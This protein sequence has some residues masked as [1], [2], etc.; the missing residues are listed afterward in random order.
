MSEFAR[1]F[2]DSVER[3]DFK[4]G[5][6]ITGVVASIEG[7]NVY[8]HCGLK[9]DARIP[10]HEFADV[11]TDISV[12]VGEEVEVALWSTDNGHGETIVSRELARRIQ[13]WKDLGEAYEKG[14]SV[15]GAI[16][17]RIKGGFVVEIQALRAFLPGSLI[18]VRPLYDSTEL[19]NQPLQFKVIKFDE[20]R[21]NV[22]VSR[23]AVLLE[24]MRDDREGLLAQIQEGD[25]RE[26]T[27]KNLTSYGAF[28][29]LGGIDG[30]LHNS[31]ISWKRVQHPSDVLKQGDKIKVKVLSFE[32][33]RIRISLGMKQL[34]PD[35]WDDLGEKYPPGTRHQGRVTSVREYG[36]FV[37]LSE[38]VEGLV[39]SSQMDWLNPKPTP[40][41][42][43]SVDDEVEVQ[44]LEVDYERKRISL[45]LKQCRDN[46]WEKFES[47]AQIGD[48][49]KGSIRDITDFGIFVAIGE[50]MDG[51]VHLSDISWSK[52]GEEA[53]KEF[54]KGQDV[55][56]VL[57]QFDRERE[58]IGLGLKQLEEDPF[59][60]FVQKH[61]R[62]S[63]A[64]GKVVEV[65]ERRA[66]V[67][68]GEEMVAELSA[69]EISSEQRVEDARSVLQVGQEIDVL[70]KSLDY[71]HRRVE[72]SMAALERKEHVTRMTEHR[73]EVKGKKGV[74][75][76][77]VMGDLEVG[78]E[79]GE[80]AAD[81]AEEKPA[82]K[83]AAS[84]KAS[85]AET[86][87]AEAA[88]AADAKDAEA[89]APKAAEAA[90]A[91]GSGAAEKGEEGDS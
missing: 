74:T 66:K 50:G 49:L 39:H 47:T 69:G 53:V 24:A 62:N 64:K 84:D 48:R 41:R 70:I 90:D 75:L 54:R 35:P 21:N 4:R 25:V 81:G 42:L 86:E 83:K 6:L 1:L 72:V 27:V 65:E 9:S 16:K 51:L 33:D 91:E 36:C 15:T 19:E 26:G 43:V 22:V 76:G 63:Q 23:R 61:P 18:D 45:G 55:E 34:E 29:D 31:D 2:E 38:G 52:P 85:K 60:D 28:V 89:E 37:E 87:A 79:A 77:D 10:K 30:L 20:A 88:Q 40:S 58:R 59:E 12:E 44:V 67:E 78:G 5:R 46:P 8:L 7:D 71:R 13:A 82:E 73:K 3:L 68:I 11:D 17:G 56:V 57:L 14:T 80:K 32:R